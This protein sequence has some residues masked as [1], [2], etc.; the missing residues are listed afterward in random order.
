MKLHLGN[1]KRN[2][3]LVFQLRMNN[4][5]NIIVET[6]GIQKVAALGLKHVFYFFYHKYFQLKF[7]ILIELFN[8]VL[9]FNYKIINHY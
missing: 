4:D 3:F 2:S 9:K 1:E 8:F 5:R 7:D 6:V